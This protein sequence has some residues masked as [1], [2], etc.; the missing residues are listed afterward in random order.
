MVTA[1]RPFTS[2]STFGMDECPSF[3]LT[4]IQHMLDDLQE[5]SENYHS[6]ARRSDRYSGGTWL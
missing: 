6:G 5:M 2:V 4:S 3:N 1:V